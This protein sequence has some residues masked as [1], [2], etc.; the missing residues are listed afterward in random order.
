MLALD[1][2]EPLTVP[3]LTQKLR[4]S[5]RLGVGREARGDQGIQW[6]GLCAPVDASVPAS[7]NAFYSLFCPQWS[8]AAPTTEGEQKAHEGESPCSWMGPLLLS[9][10]CVDK[11]WS[12]F[13][14]L[15]V[16]WGTRL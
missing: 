10:V 9:R 16:G 4:R 11:P 5:W 13:S 3:C 12:S 6:P 14:V 8:Q 1:L 7:A 15:G 2:Q